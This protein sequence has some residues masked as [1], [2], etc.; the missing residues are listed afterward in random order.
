MAGL[1]I[2]RTEHRLRP[3]AR[4]VIANPCLPGEEIVP[5]GDS[6]AG[7][8]MRRI[9]QIPESEVEALR[10]ELV[11]G[12]PR[13]H[14]AFEALLEHHFE[15]VAHPIGPDV[16]PLSR[17]RRLVIGAYF[18]HEYSVEGAALFN[19]SLVAAPDQGQLAPGETRV[20]MSLRAVG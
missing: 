15:L 5:G 8:L 18:T 13:R 19:P 14:L 4:R 20:V 11:S 3:D 9:L 7:L 1:A 6:R 10:E 17:D 2:R 16:G 12:F